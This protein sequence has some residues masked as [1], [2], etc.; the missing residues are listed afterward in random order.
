[1]RNAGIIISIL[2]PVAGGAFLLFRKQMGESTRRI[3]CE[4]FA[5]LTSVIVWTVLLS[6]RVEEFTGNYE[7]QILAILTDW[8]AMK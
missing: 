5:C 2:L 7:E 1:M 8:D 3:W 4:V 6:G